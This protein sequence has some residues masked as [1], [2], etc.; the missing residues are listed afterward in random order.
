MPFNFKAL[1]DYYVEE[2]DNNIYSQFDDA[3]MMDDMNYQIEA[4]RS[5]AIQLT[6]QLQEED[7]Q[8]DQEEQQ[9]EYNVEPFALSYYWEILE[10]E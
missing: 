2:N 7:D 6:M 1:Y 10:I 9:E 8:Y 4:D 3:R 5:L